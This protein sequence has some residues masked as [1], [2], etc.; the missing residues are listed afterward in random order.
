MQFHFHETASLGVSGIWLGAI[1]G[2]RDCRDRISRGRVILFVLD[3]GGNHHTPNGL[4]GKGGVF[5][6]REGKGKGIG[7]GRGDVHVC[8]VVTDDGIGM[9]DRSR[10]KLHLAVSLYGGVIGQL[11]ADRVG[12]GSKV[13]LP[14]SLLAGHLGK[15][16]LVRGHVAV[17]IVL[18]DRDRHVKGAC[19][20]GIVTTL[21]LTGKPCI[22]N[23]AEG[24]DAQKNTEN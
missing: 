1:R 2:S 5:G 11:E 17:C 13:A 24:Y 9:V 6:H 12:S 14:D 10:A 7:S 20:E 23:G 3:V 8:R 16:D 19:G 18:E 4:K 15:S 22:G 21:R